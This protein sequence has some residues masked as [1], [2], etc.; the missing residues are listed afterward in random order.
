MPKFVFPHLMGGNVVIGLVR[1]KRVRLVAGL[2]IVIAIICLAGYWLWCSITTV[3]IVDA[4]VR[5]DAVTLASEVDGVV[6][7]VFVTDGERANVGDV[8]IQ[9]DDRRSGLVVQERLAR[10]KSL[11]QDLSRLTLSYDIAAK[12]LKFQKEDLDAELGQAKID[13]MIAAVNMSEAKRQ[14]GQSRDLFRAGIASENEFQTVSVLNKISALSSQRA[15]LDQKR[16]QMKMDAFTLQSR[17]LNA[18]QIALKVTEANLQEAKIQYEVAV[19]DQHRHKVICRHAGIVARL[20]VHEGDSVSR[21]Q[22]LLIQHDPKTARIE[23]NVKESDLRYFYP[24]KR[25]RVSLDE[26]PGNL[27]TGVITNVGTIST[28]MYSELPLQPEQGNFIRVAQKIPVEVS[29]DV[30]HRR[31]VPGTLAKVLATRKL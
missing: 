31:L 4:K 19:Y 3:T 8:L 24:G 13:N 30:G 29:V 15:A 26:Y 12:R 18:Q 28:N 25:V 9:I 2:L 20:F 17:E 1:L 27:F 6:T 22:R 16:A 10:V 14:F 5:E 11:T 21:G 7:K 23:A